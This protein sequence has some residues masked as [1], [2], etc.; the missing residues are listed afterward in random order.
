MRVNQLVVDPV[1]AALRQ[2]VDVQLAG[3]E[4]HFTKSAVDLVTIDVDIGKIVVGADFLY[5]AQGVLQSAP[6]PQADVLQRVLIIYRVRGLGI[7]VCGKLLS[8]HFIKVI[9]SP[10][11]LDIVNDVRFLANQLIRRDNEAAYVPSR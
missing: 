4:H 7:G 5:L 9:S 8:R 11:R 2:F 6:V 3:G 1:A 10:R